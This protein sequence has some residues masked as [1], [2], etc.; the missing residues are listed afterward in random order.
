MK[1]FSLL[2]IIV[3]V[4]A[5]SLA[6]N[7]GDFEFRADGAVSES[8]GGDAGDG[9]AE[10][11]SR[12]DS[13]ECSVDSDCDG[14][15]NATV[16]CNS[17]R[18]EL[19][20][21]VGTFDNC[22]G[23]D[24][25]G[26]E[27]NVGSDPNNCGSCGNQCERPNS[28]ASCVSGSCVIT[29]CDENFDNCDSDDG[30]GCEASLTRPGTCGGC[31]IMCT[32]E[33]LCSAT[34]D[35]P[36]CVDGCEDGEDV[37]SG[38]CVL[39]DS[40]VEHCGSCGMACPEFSN[41]T[42]TCTGR[43]CGGTCDAGFEDCD[44]SAANGCEIDTARNVEHCG[45]CDMPCA[46][47]TNVAT[48]SCEDSTCGV[49]T[50]TGDFA[51][52]DDSPG[53]G[54][55]IDTAIDP[56]HCGGC[57]MACALDNVVAHACA[58]STCEVT[59]CA[60]GF[61]DCNTTDSD[62]CE[63]DLNTSAAHCGGCGRVCSGTCTDG[64]CSTDV[65]GVDSGAQG[66]CAVLRSGEVWCFGENFYGELG[67]AD[68]LPRGSATQMDTPLRFSQVEVHNGHACGINVADEKVYCWGHNNLGQRGDGTSTAS[69]SASPRA[70]VSG[71]AVTT[72]FD[73]AQFVQI[74]RGAAHHCALS[75]TGSVWCW[76][77]NASNQ[78]GQSS[79]TSPIRSA[80]KVDLP[81]PASQIAVGH[82]HSCAML[83]N[84]Q[85]WCW[86]E[87]GDGQLGR[88]NTTDGLPADTGL[89]N[90]DGIAAGGA[91][92][93]AVDMN[94]ALWCWGNGSR[95]QLLTGT[96]DQT[97]PVEMTD[98]GLIDEVSVDN[99]VVVARRDSTWFIWGRNYFGQFG[100]GTEDAVTNHGVTEM[101]WLPAG[102]TSVVPGYRTTCAI[103]DGDL[104]CWGDNREAATGRV[105]LAT[106]PTPVDVTD[107]AT[108]VDG[109][110]QVAAGPLLSC[111]RRSVTGGQRVQCWGG[112][113]PSTALGSTGRPSNWASAAA[114]DVNYTVS[115]TLTDL[116]AGNESGCL[117][118]DGDVYCWGLALGSMFG[119]D[120]SPPPGGLYSTPTNFTYPG[121]T[122]VDE[123]SLGHAFMC[124]RSGTEAKCWGRSSSGQT[125]VVMAS[126]PPPAAPLNDS[127]GINPMSITTIEAGT[128]GACA[129]ETAGTL[130]CWGDGY[131][132][133]GSASGVHAPTQV[134]DA[135]GT[136]PLAQVSSVAIGPGH[137]CAVADADDRV[138]CWGD[139]GSGQL[140]RIAGGNSTRP[141]DTGVTGAAQVVA[142]RD[143]SCARLAT[144]AVHCWGGNEVGQLG[145]GTTTDDFMPAPVVGVSDA[146][147]LDAAIDTADGRRHGTH[148]CAARSGGEVTCW[149]GNLYGRTGGGEDVRFLTP[150]EV[151]GLP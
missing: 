75:V 37:C 27:L 31:S 68:R 73:S 96:S 30:N 128:H 80:M 135:S 108:P 133:N 33:M 29:S 144:G 97:L 88:G 84:R 69:P 40:N 87:N 55:E 13:G 42:R 111:V 41:G 137:R 105:D 57:T 50:C 36:R 20:A 8:D 132:G 148:V 150:G 4:S 65:V 35:T 151:V 114:I 17:G 14:L 89:T 117:V 34:G 66:T 90:M 142:G 146:I 82:L 26:C 7:K 122:N 9:G 12:V 134:M 64:L 46:L 106:R 6:F 103:A 125:G 112:N 109:A 86:G 141:F 16:A 71:D 22:D 110:A 74:G 23:D 70:V 52:C 81:A 19:D 100:D 143:F 140:G 77:L 76:G 121:W 60:T 119:T 93:C 43:A 56:M 126:V 54:C 129:I 102:V 47:G 59:T 49:A 24:T 116:D 107:G 28:T 78:V 98:A 95:G 131:A 120:P 127:G 85:V 61:G 149:G 72:E 44:D 38:S 139:N 147:D 15:Q 123:V 101:T 67:F 10:D 113:G 83:T 136:N 124:A 99:E 130:T 104:Y 11:S 3:S 5:C 53:N 58:D 21:C 145:R 32:S 18:C 45:G 48:A 1:I 51:D 25:N 39:L 92:T 62:G 115:S 118:D 94:R 138:Y 63:I 79:A 2:G 91:V